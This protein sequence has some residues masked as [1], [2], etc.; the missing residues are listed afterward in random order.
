[1][2]S[3]EFV[4]AG[5]G[6]FAGGVEPDFAA[7]PSPTQTKGIIFAEIGAGFGIDDAIEERI[8]ICAVRRVAARAGHRH[9]MYAP[10][11][12]LRVR[13]N[14]L[15]QRVA[16]EELKAAASVDSRDKIAVLLCRSHSVAE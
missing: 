10:E 1:M 14:H 11:V 12:S 9:T 16:A 8:Q 5:V 13:R 2:V 4:R 15:L 7:C 6:E 3:D